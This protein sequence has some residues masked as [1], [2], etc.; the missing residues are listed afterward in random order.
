[1]AITSEDVRA[2]QFRRQLRG[3]AIEEVDDFLDDVATELDRLN[4]II[5]ELEGRLADRGAR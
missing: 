1:M 3:Y 5:R 2:S 4:V